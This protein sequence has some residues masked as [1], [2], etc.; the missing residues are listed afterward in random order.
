MP[1]TYRKSTDLVGMVA[2]DLKTPISAVRGY[3][4]LIQHA[5]ELNEQQRLYCE[6]A[7]G[8]LDRMEL[9]IAAL[10]DINQIEGETQMNWQHC[11]LTPIIGGAVDLLETLANQRGIALHVD[12]DAHL[13]AVRGDPQRLSQ[14]IHNLLSNA[15]KYNREGGAVWISAASEP[16]FVRV[17]VRDTG[18]GIAPEDQPHVFDRFFRAAQKTRKPI[19]GTGLGLSIVR[20]IIDKH[21]GY[22]WVESTPGEGSTFSFTLPKPARTRDGHDRMMEESRHGESYE[23]SH[24]AGRIEVPIE[25]PDAVD[26]NLQES[27]GAVENDSASDLV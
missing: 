1:H 2:H 14:V 19:E 10:L 17:S 24:H 8:G 26:D 16:G 6:R 9:L 13:E 4:E 15:I 25:E 12:V 22:I 20:M 23:R 11:Q 7:L 18:I 3:I 5:G 21:G 27:N